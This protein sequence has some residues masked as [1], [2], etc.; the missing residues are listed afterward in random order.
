MLIPMCAAHT[1]ARASRRVY[2]IGTSGGLVRPSTGYA[3]LAIQRS[4]QAFADRLA[5]S[6][7]AAPPEPRDR[8]ALYFAG[9]NPRPPRLP[10]AHPSFIN[11]SHKR[12]RSLNRPV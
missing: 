4:T 12:T 6:P 9:G 2:R 1:P 10:A 7:L 8:T 11:P 3:F 5:R